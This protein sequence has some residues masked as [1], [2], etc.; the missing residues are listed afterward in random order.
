M[1]INEQ[2]NSEYLNYYAN[3]VITERLNQLCK[4]VHNQLLLSYFL[5]IIFIISNLKNNQCT[6]ESKMIYCKIN[7]GYL[8]IEKYLVCY[9]G[10]IFG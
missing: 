5:F 1:S 2:F 9:N 8:P 3:Y 10:K 6:S 7:F 4:W